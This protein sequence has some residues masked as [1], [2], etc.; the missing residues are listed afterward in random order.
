MLDATK[1]KFNDVTLERLNGDEPATK[2]L[3]NQYSVQGYPTLVM[4]DSGGTVLYNGGS[5]QDPDSLY[6]LINRYH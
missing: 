2:A 6:A 5:P 4:L 1:A 3:M